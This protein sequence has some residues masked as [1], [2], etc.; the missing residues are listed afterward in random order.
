MKLTLALQQQII[1]AIGEDPDRPLILPDWAYQPDDRERCMVYVQRIPMDLH[2]HLHNMLI[3][4]LGHHE[5]MI[6]RGGPRNINPFLFDVVAGRRSRRTH[7][8]RGHEYTPENEA[9]PN[10]RGYRCLTCLRETYGFTGQ[11]TGAANRL[12]THCPQGHEYT[13]ANTRHTKDGRR[14]CITCTR[15]RQRDYMR[16]RRATEKKEQNR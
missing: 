14:R 10:P 3:R 7:C 1:T 6:Q 15:E 13:K 4:P 9:P 2:R 11:G 8:N 5:V 12:K 16:A